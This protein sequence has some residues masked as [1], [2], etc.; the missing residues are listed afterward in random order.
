MRRAVDTALWTRVR[1]P[2][3]NRHGSLERHSAQITCGRCG[4]GGSLDEF[5][6]TFDEKQIDGGK[7]FRYTVTR[8]FS[9]AK[10][11]DLLP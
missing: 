4:F 3:C 2:E 6:V 9:A 8:I 10:Q 7:N 1:C 11:R 5:Q